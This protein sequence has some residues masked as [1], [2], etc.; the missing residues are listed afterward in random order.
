MDKIRLTT[1]RFDFYSDF[2]QVFGLILELQMC[3]GEVKSTKNEDGFNTTKV[4]HGCAEMHQ[5]GKFGLTPTFQL[6]AKVFFF[7]P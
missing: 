7:S 4:S 5:V 1:C 3:P 2:N 6:W